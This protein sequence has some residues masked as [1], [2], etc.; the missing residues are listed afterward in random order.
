MLEEGIIPK[1]TLA[2]K[3]HPTISKY[4]S[5]TIHFWGV[6]LYEKSPPLAMLTYWLN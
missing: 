6:C 4:L 3:L 2:Q 5:Q 1:V